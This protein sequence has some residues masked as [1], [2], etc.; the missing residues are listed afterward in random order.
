MANMTEIRSRM[1]SIQET[2]KITNAMYLIS[3]TKL[4]KAR[5]KLDATAPYFEL[6]QSTIKDILFHSPDINH[7]FFDQRKKIKPEDKKAGLCGH[8]GRQGDG[9]SLQ[10]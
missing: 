4:R 10:P 7:T 2:M 8:D 9:W 6:L 1:K 3:S 5:E